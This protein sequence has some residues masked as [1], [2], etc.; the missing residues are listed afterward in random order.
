MVLRK[1]RSDKLLTTLLISFLI[2]LIP[3]DNC[4]NAFNLWWIRTVG[5]SPLM[6]AP[7]LYAV[8]FTVFGVK[9]SYPR[10]NLLLLILVCIGTILFG[11]G[12]QWRILWYKLS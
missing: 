10:I 1:K 5:A 8:L 12:H 3:N 4:Q 6:Y 2:L 9:G 11:L 7:N